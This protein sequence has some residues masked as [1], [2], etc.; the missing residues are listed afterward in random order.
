MAQL[1]KVRFLGFDASCLI[2]SLRTLMPNTLCQVNSLAGLGNIMELQEKLDSERKKLRLFIIKAKQ[3]WEERQDSMEVRGETNEQ[4]YYVASIGEMIGPSNEYKV[5]ESIGRGVFSSVFRCKHIREGKDYAIKFVR[6]NTM[7][8]KA[9]E[10]EV[11]MYR[12]LAKQGA[13]VDAEGLPFLISLAGVESFVHV[14][15]LCMVLDLHHK[16]EPPPPPPKV[17]EKYNQQLAAWECIALKK[18]QGVCVLASSRFRICFTLV[19]S[20]H[21]S[22]YNC[23]QRDSAILRSLTF[24]SVTCAPL[25]RSMGRAAACPSS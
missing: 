25:S 21:L 10:R 24:T 6:S 5:E 22:T 19:K 11:E 16:L 23:S 13:K 15:H 3:D 18:P 14:G 20:M 4:E 9:G 1:C 12:R 2:L 7:M 8:H 17:Q